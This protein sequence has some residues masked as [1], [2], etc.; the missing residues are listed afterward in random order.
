MISHDSNSAILF[1]T[2]LSFDPNRFKALSASPLLVHSSLARWPKYSSSDACVDRISITDISRMACNWPVM[3]V[4]GRADLRHELPAQ[5]WAVREV[6]AIGVLA[7]VDGGVH[8]GGYPDDGGADMD[9]FRQGVELRPPR[10]VFEVAM[11]DLH[12]FFPP[13]L[14]LGVV[15]D[16]GVVW[17]VDGA[18]LGHPGLDLRPDGETVHSVGVVFDHELELSRARWVLHC[19]SPAQKQIAV[20]PLQEIGGEGLVGEIPALVDDGRQLHGVFGREDGELDDTA[21]VDKSLASES[22][23]VHGVAVVRDEELVDG[24]KCAE[25][26]VR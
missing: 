18:V 8:G 6:A 10:L 7:E 23:Y 11:S 5:A 15:T 20:I 25:V 13:G 1:S 2:S 19:H 24:M 17:V 21:G 22:V 12:G 16:D 3:L 4:V 9:E 14:E 26:P